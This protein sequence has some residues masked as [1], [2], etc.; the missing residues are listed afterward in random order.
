MKIG[1]QAKLPILSLVI[2]PTSLGRG[3]D[4]L[5]TYKGLRSQHLYLSGGADACVLVR[6]VHVCNYNLIFNQST[7]NQIHLYDGRQIAP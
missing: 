3:T 7:R 4:I 1:F 2:V 6:K 5:C